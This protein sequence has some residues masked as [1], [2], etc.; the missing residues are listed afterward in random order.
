MFHF[1]ALLLLCFYFFLSKTHYLSQKYAIPF[2]MLIYLVYL[3]YCKICDR[4]EGYKD[5][6]LASLIRI[7]TM[8][9]GHK[10]YL[11]YIHA[12]CIIIT[13]CC[14]GCMVKHIQYSV[15][16]FTIKHSTFYDCTVKFNV[17]KM[18]TLHGPS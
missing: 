5:T 9:K 18:R 17:C 15:N 4:L 6:D 10:V 3:T 14:A 1:F 2:T 16:L 12:S 11:G 8:Y 7:K 13:K